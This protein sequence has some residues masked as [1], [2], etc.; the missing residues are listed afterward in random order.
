MPFLFDALFGTSFPA[1]SS[2]LDRRIK[3]CVAV[4]VLSQCFNPNFSL[5][6]GALTALPSIR[7]EPIRL[8]TD[9]Y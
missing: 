6:S 7:R 1:I 5:K 2:S 8:T 9:R 3:L 4:R